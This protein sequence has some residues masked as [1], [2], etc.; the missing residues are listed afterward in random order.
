MQGIFK[1]IVTAIRKAP[2]SRNNI[3]TIISDRALNA[4]SSLMLELNDIVTVK[5]LDSDDRGQMISALE[6]EGKAD[7][8]EP[9]AM[10]SEMI[11][12]LDLGQNA[13][14]MLTSH[15]KKPY[16]DTAKKMSA[17]LQDAAATFLKGYLAGAPMAVRFHND[18]DG[19][20][21]AV[22]LY[23][24]LARLDGNVVEGP[25]GLSW[26]MQRGIE[27]DDASM[28][29]DFT[30][31]S[32][33]ESVAR[34]IVFITDFG[35]APGSEDQFRDAAKKV[36]VVMLDHHPV[37]DT[38]PSSA[39]RHYINPWE[40]GGDS[41]FTAGLLT[42]LFAEI[43]HPVET[44]DMILAS[45]I[46][47]YSTFADRSNKA[48]QRDGIL[49][50]YLTSIAGRSDSHIE[51]LTPR[52]M[53]SILSDRERADAMFH[54][55][56][57][58]MNE[59]LE[60]GVSGVKSYKCRD[61]ITAFVLDFRSLPRSESGYPLPGRYSSRLQEKL[62]SINGARTIAI[63]HYG[64]YIT[65]RLSKEISQL[66]GMLKII[67]KLEEESEYVGSGGGHNEAASIKID[68][69]GLKSVMKMLLSEL[70]ASYS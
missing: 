35:T 63:V 38:F 47:D 18:G 40:H 15:L 49:L 16:I 6:I 33:F 69:D 51:K 34:P 41:N 27:Y 67:K 13:K 29:N 4:R 53:E 28:R 57:N 36:D 44:S 59:M 45:L 12:G 3:Y 19:A 32:N 42:S 17:Q 66:V 20:S 5:Q 31:F 1:G 9:E 56:A 46:S 61:G 52:Y 30:E 23:R 68:P 22:S 14:K 65:L 54:S 39:L 21:G 26:I 43:I 8:K 24:A 64:S 48:G 60:L 62:E 7:A 10:L 55:A 25:R 50:D 70:G 58:M 37:Y 11:R 2:D